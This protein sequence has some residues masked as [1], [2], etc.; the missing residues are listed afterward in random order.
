MTPKDFTTHTFDRVLHKNEPEVVARN[1]MDILAR[2]GN[3][4]GMMTWD[5]YKA[6]RLQDGNFS[7]SEKEYFFQVSPYCQSEHAA[8]LFSPAWNKDTTP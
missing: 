5:Y 7:E 1:I 6:A 2:T 4:F 8:R 3:T